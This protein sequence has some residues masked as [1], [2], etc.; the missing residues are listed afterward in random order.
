LTARGGSIPIEMAFNAHTGGYA[1]FKVRK[2]FDE[3][4]KVWTAA[5][6]LRF[7]VGFS[8]AAGPKANSR[9]LQLVQAKDDR[10]DAT[11]GRISYESARP[12]GRRSV[13]RV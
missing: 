11:L 5:A 6:R 1:G 7:F 12:S 3:K 8:G 10:V 13:T 2:A 9:S 4:T